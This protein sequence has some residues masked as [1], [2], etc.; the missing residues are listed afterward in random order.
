MTY[1][2]HKAISCTMACYSEKGYFI[3][4][5]EFVSIRAAKDVAS[6]I[7]RKRMGGRYEISVE[8]RGL[9][10]RGRVRKHQCF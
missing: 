2:N 8:G 5:G 6:F 1:N 4:G 7:L 10:C 3:T 9:I